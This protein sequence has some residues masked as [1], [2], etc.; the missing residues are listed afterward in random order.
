MVAEG[1]YVYYK[2]QIGD[3]VWGKIS[4]G[5]AEVE[6]KIESENQDGDT[7]L[8]VSRHPLLFPT[9]HQHGWSSH[10]I[11]SKALVLNS[12]DLGLGPGTYSIGIYGFKGTTK[13]KVSV[14]I[15]DKSNLKIDS[16]PYL[17]HCLLME[18]Q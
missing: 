15:R 5:D 6:V 13:Y 12:R 16:K 3:D 17:P 11:G 4:S 14:S 1:S 7:D 2:F 8:Y 18:I 9:Q 10:D